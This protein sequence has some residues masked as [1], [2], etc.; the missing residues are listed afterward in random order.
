MQIQALRPLKVAAD[1]EARLGALPATLEESYWD[2]Y[3][4]ILNSGQHATELALFTF[5]WLMYAQDTINIEAFACLASSALQP[6]GSPGF[7]PTEIS[8]VCS[9]LIVVRSTSFEFAHL[10]VREFL[11]ELPKR[12][13]NQ[14]LP[15][16][17]HGRVSIACLRLLP[18]VLP[19]MSDI[20]HKTKLD[21][22]LESPGPLSIGLYSSDEANTDGFHDSEPSRPNE[23]D[24]AELAGRFWVEHVCKSHDARK[25]NPPSDLIKSFLLDPTRTEISPKYQQ[26]CR[27]LA[28]DT[29]EHDH[30]LQ[31]S[32][33]EPPNPIW[34]ACLHGWIEVVEFLYAANYEDL[35]QPRKTNPHFESLRCFTGVDL[36][37]QGKFP[38]GISPLWFAVLS[39]NVSLTECIIELCK[40]PL[41]AQLAV[42]TKPLIQAAANGNIDLLTTLLRKE[43]TPGVETDAFVTAAANGHSYVLDVLITHNPLLVSTAGY[44]A[45]YGACMGGEPNVANF[46]LDKGV[47]TDRGANFLHGAAFS[48]HS[49]NVLEVLLQRRVGLDG[50]SKALIIA[51]SHGDGKKTALLLQHGAQEEPAAVIRAIKQDTPLTAIRLIKAG[52]DIKAHYFQGRRWTPL[53]YAAEKGFEKVIEALL[54][55]GVQV[56][57]YDNDEQTPL[58]TAAKMGRVACVRILLDSGADVLAEDGEGRIPLDLA[59]IKGHVA[60]ETLIRDR[61][62][63][64]L[65]ELQR[66]KEKR[67][68]ADS[69]AGTGSSWIS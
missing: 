9:N 25:L 18:D 10:S 62:V 42:T 8:D 12:D 37:I 45:M 46:L 47:A 49:S 4:E 63:R 3:Q 56:N 50:L 67:N 21:S 13:I 28:K 7:T 26:W 66:E 36:D 57:V 27:L 65:E 68:I 59:E 43:H 69:V 16:T 61:M 64:L 29:V 6:E 30:L 40:D 31:F 52:F 54:G 14:L 53:H 20:D 2:I 23:L 38:N 35:E 24:V 19:L 60:C 11:E 22:L 15:D 44:S 34:L 17:S 48:K 55:S 32:A 58:H 39:N 33:M 5:Q 1:I 51:V 41:Q